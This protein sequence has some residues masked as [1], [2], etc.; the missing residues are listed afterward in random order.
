[1]NPKIN[2]NNLVRQLVPPHRRQPVRL[3]FLRGLLYPLR[4]L[5]E[6][7]E[8]WRDDIRLRINVN[9]QVMVLEGYLRN[10][11][12]DVRITITSLDNGWLWVGL[13]SEGDLYMPKIGLLGGGEQLI[14]V[15]LLWEKRLG[16]GDVDFWVYIPVGVDIE[17]IRAEIECYRQ[18]GVKYEIIQK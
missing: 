8:L 16:M 10:K 11:Y 7:F 2:I 6:W 17:A 18:A 4:Q 14:H 3:D 13:L 5:W 12:N 15:P 9:S 1:M